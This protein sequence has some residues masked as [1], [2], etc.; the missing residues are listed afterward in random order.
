VRVLC[1]HFI[2]S[3]DGQ[4]LLEYVLLAAVIALGTFTGMTAVRDGLNTEFS[5]ISTSVTSAS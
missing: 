1:E 5:N 3:E 2:R 4:D